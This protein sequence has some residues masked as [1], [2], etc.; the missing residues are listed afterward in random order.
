MIKISA[1]LSA[2]KLLML[3]EQLN[4]LYKI[5]VDAIHYDIEDGNFT[6]DMTLGLNLLKELDIV[7]KIPIHVH[8]MTNNP[9][10]IILQL[11]KRSISHVSFHI[12]AC[13]YP[14]RVIRLIHDNGFIPGIAFNLS[15]DIP[16]LF[17]LSPYLKFVLALSSDPEIPNSPFVP[18]TL[19][20]II[21]GQEKNLSL[22]LEWVIDGG[23]NR[24]NIHL[25]RSAGIHTCV[26]GR[27]LFQDGSI[28]QNYR[29]IINEI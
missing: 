13:L 4:L 15:T 2:A 16:S 14:R 26:I 10:A 21:R 24:Q 20:K 18:Q 17:Y 29:R 6:P 23:I 27:A 9:E 5:G 7:S 8:L 1:S 28:E 19:E 3:E 12:E 22:N 11:P 25:L